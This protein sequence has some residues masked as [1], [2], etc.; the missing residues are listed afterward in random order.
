MLLLA[1]ALL[2]GCGGGKSGAK[3]NG[4]AAKPA[5]QVLDDAKSAAVGA[6]SLHVTGNIKSGGTPTSLDLTL[7]QG[8]GAKGSMSASGFQFDLIRIGNAVYIR[9]SDAFLEHFAGGAASLFH[10]KWLKASAKT[11]GFA[12]LTPL[13][14]P[15][16]L[17]G[18]IA[19]GHGKLVNDG[20]TTY[21]GQQV[22]EIRDTSDDSKLY[23]AATGTAYPVAIVGGKKG[24]SGAISFGDWNKPVSISA[25]QSAISLSKIG[26][27]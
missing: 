5:V 24:G 1:L 16:A 4:E 19:K 15:S 10:G 2:A 9:G 7:V 3:S 6:T 21:E 18:A 17:F 20:L 11:G 27:G 22:V 26:S 23:V 8:K 25:P 12:S 14:T 13:T